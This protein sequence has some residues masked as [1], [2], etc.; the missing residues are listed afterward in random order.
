MAVTKEGENSEIQFG[1]RALSCLRRIRGSAFEWVAR[2]HPTVEAVIA[3]SDAER[4]GGIAASY[5]IDNLGNPRSP[6]SELSLS[7]SLAGIEK[8]YAPYKEF[9]ISPDWSRI[10]LRYTLPSRLDSFR[11][12]AREPDPKDNDSLWRHSIGTDNLKQMPDLDIFNNRLGIISPLSSDYLDAVLLQ[13]FIQQYIQGPCFKLKPL[14][15]TPALDWDT[16]PRYQQRDDRFATEVDM[17]AIW[18]NL[19]VSFRTRVA[20]SRAVEALYPEKTKH[21]LLLVA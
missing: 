9:A 7:T 8:R 13:R 12:L 1:E 5:L 6:Q 21:G 17:I 11:F 3:V 15:L 19:D 20:T 10:K 14:V 2:P 18:T 16:N 4:V